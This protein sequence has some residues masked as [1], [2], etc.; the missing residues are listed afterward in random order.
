MAVINEYLINQYRQV[1]KSKAY[2]D[3]SVRFVHMLRFIIENLQAKTVLDYGCGQSRLADR[4]AEAAG[5]KCFRYDPSIDEISRMPEGRYDFVIC[6][7]VMEHVKEDDCVDVIR[8]IKSLSD[9]AFFHIATR[10]AAQILPDGQ[11]AHC[12]V[13]PDKWWMEKISAEF[14]GSEMIFTEENMGCGIVTFVPAAKYIYQDIYYGIR[15]RQA[16]NVQ[17]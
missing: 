4:I 13:K 17:S 8:H 2:G 3:T 1:H 11:N 15:F 12:T 7:D 10:P 5:V 6:T 16:N 9:N 14:P